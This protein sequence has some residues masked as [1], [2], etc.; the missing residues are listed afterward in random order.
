[1]KKNQILIVAGIILLLI[2]GGVLYWQGKDQ[3]VELVEVGIVENGKGEMVEISDEIDTSDW[4]TI[5]MKNM[6]LR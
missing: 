3:N 4:K 5:G 2:L 1:M 6:G